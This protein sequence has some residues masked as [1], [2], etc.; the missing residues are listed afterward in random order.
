MHSVDERDLN[1]TLSQ[2]LNMNG[3]WDFSVLRTTVPHD[4]IDELN[5]AHIFLNEEPDCILW[6]EM[7]SG[8]FTCQSAY[9]TLRR[10]QGTIAPRRTD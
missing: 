10:R 3:Y 9:H 7:A 2:V 8:V 1:I 4:L 5:S 6:N